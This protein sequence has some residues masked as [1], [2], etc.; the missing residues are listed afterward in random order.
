MKIFSLVLLLISNISY[1]KSIYIKDCDNNIFISNALIFDE[2]NNL[3]GSTNEYGIIEISNQQIIKISHPKYG[4][5]THHVEDIICIDNTT[6]E[7]IIIETVAHVKGEL[8]SHLNNSRQK[9]LN[10]KELYYNVENKVIWKENTVESYKGVA[11]SVI[12]NKNTNTSLYNHDIMISPKIKEIDGYYLVE[13]FKFI[14]KYLPKYTL[15]NNNKSFNL[16]EERVKVSQVSKVGNVYFIYYKDNYED[17]I[18]FEI[19]ESKLIKR[20][21]NTSTLWSESKNTKNKKLINTY[22]DIKYNFSNLDE[23]QDIDISET[24]LINDQPISIKFN[25]SIYKGNKSN[26]KDEKKGIKFALMYMKIFTNT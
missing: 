23:F 26:L 18:S 8:L 24:L 3:I 4:S 14:D 12:S 25:G 5:N 20:Y 21:I 11:K 2:N 7:E 17:Y 16:L 9:I 22:T 15:F 19:D 1:A 10:I 13:S 6:L